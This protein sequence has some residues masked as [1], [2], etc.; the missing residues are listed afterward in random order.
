MIV[1]TIF[2][3]VS[4]GTFLYE[5]GT[6]LSTEDL[7]LLLHP[8]RPSSLFALPNDCQQLGVMTYMV[9]KRSLIFELL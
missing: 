9:R 8:P 2:G 7:T 5:I 4:F 3:V 1:T 6:L